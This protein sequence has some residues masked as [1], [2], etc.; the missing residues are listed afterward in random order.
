VSHRIPFKSRRKSPCAQQ[1]SLKSCKRLQT[2]QQSL[3]LQHQDDLVNSASHASLLEVNGQV[4][5]LG[6]LIWVV[7]TSEALDLTVACLG[8]DTAL[9]GLLGVLEGSSD[10]DEVEVTILL[11][12]L[13]G[14]LASILVW[15]DWSSNDGCARASELRRNECDTADVAGTVC[16]AEAQF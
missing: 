1:S 16:A 9:V 14:V 11:D 12:D 6:S 3:A 2:I 8:I 4:G 7:D 5:L 10:V 13:A 15:C